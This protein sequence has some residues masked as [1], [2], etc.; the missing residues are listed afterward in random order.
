MQQPVTEDVIN[1]KLSSGEFVLKPFSKGKSESWENFYLI[2]DKKNEKEQGFVQCKKCKTYLKYDDSRETK[3]SLDNH[4]CATNA[5]KLEREIALFQKQK[6]PLSVEMKKQ[7]LNSFV[8]FY[9]KNIKLET[10]KDEE[11]E[12]LKDGTF[13]ILAQILIATGAVYGPRVTNDILSLITTEAAYAVRERKF[14]ISKL[15]EVI[16][17]PGSSATINMWTNDLFPSFSHISITV[18]CFAEDW[19]L[20]SIPLCSMNFQEEKK[21]GED[22]KNNVVETMVNFEVEVLMSKLIFV[23]DQ[24]P[25]IVKAFQDNNRLNC[26]SHIINTI[27]HHT[28]NEDYLKEKLPEIQRVIQLLSNFEKLLKEYEFSKNNLEHK[29]LQEIETRWDSKFVILKSI[30]DNYNRIQN[31]IVEGKFPQLGNIPK[32]NIEDLVYF[33]EVFK[34]ALDELEKKHSPTIHLVLLVKLNLEEHLKV[35]EQDSVNLKTLKERANGFLQAEYQILPIHKISLFLWPR[36][37]QLR[38]LSNTKR[39]EVMTKIDEELNVQCIEDFHITDEPESVCLAPK[40]RKISKFDEWEDI[41]LHDKSSGSVEEVKDYSN[42]S[43]SKQSDIIDFWK[44]N[45]SMFPRLAKLAKKYL[46]VPASSSFL[47]KEIKLSYRKGIEEAVE[48]LL[49]QRRMDSTANRSTEPC[50]PSTSTGSG[51]SED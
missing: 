38:M 25:N 51:A 7:I 3:S 15:N 5:Q 18:H 16:R 39:K 22:I 44:T 35:S 8:N 11:L 37:R 41:G 40:R 32:D 21:S 13:I 2:I 34:D 23:T 33:V 14:L 20:T 24:D 4:Q 17:N 30:L 36:Y 6:E 27:L 12:I 29:V 10:L 46:S 42:Y 50:I 9:I 49:L 45:Q 47:T 19:S 26:L 48:S 28:F 43:V 1:S 31:L